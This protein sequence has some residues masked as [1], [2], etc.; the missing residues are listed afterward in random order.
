MIQAVRRPTLVIAGT[1]MAGGRLVEEILTN[2]PERF[3]IRMFGADPQTL[4]DRV[5]L[6]CML[7][8][9]ADAEQFQLRPMQWFE[10]RGVLVHAGV[11]AEQIDR[12]QRLVVGGGGK[13]VE[14]YDLLVLATGS[15]PLVPALPGADLQG[16]FVLR[17]LDDW[18]GVGA[19]AHECDR[20]VI[21][22]GG[23]LGLLAERSLSKLGLEV[24]IVEKVA[25]VH[26]EGFV[27]GVE[28]P[29]GT[30]LDADLLVL[31]GGDHPNVEP[32]RLAGL[33]IAH[34]V[35]VDDQMRTSDLDIYALG[36]CAQPRIGDAPPVI[37]QARLLAGLL[38]GTGP[39]LPPPPEESAKNKVETT[40]QDK[41]GLDCLPDILKLAPANNW[42]ELTEDD[43]HRAKW[44]GLFFRKQTPGHFMMR[45][46]A[47]AGQMTAQQFRVI[48]DIS[49]EFGKGFVDITTRQQIQLRWFALRDVEEIWR[50]LELVGIHSKQTG[51]DNV[52]GVCGCPV[53]GLTPSELFDAS[54]VV[55]ELSDLIVG[56]R[57][58]TNLPRKFNVTITACLENCCHTET[59][60]IALVPAYRELEDG[61]IDGFN[62]FVGG[63]QGSGGY[64]PATPLDVF[65][66]REE[67]AALSGEIIRVFRDH[68]SRATRNR[69]RLA[70]LIEDRGIA[71]LRAEVER[72]WGRALLKSGTDLRKP[73]H[74][75]HLGIHPQKHRASDG[76]PQLYYAG[77][78]VPVGR[79]TSAQ[80]RGVADLADRHGNGDIRIT[81]GQNIIIANIPEGHIGAL[82]DEPLL[83]ELEIDPSPVMRGLVACTGTDYCHLALIET[84]GWAVQVARELEKRTAGQKLKPLTIHW[85][86]CSAGCGLHQVSTIGLQGCRS[87]VNGQVLDAA[88]VCVNGKTGPEPVVATDLMYDVPCEQLADALEPLVRYLPR[89]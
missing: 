43:K 18:L 14:P 19:F 47:N 70:F 77:M 39:E 80:L 9:V 72:R 45:L 54:P 52:R 49:D 66:R 42:Q 87:R 26:G 69:A 6:S 56:N 74:V 59:Q 65:V 29:D 75:D 62:I 71:W 60:D 55:K 41:D 27:R 48:A 3:H 40:K 35:L 11:K 67:A 73:H 1:G 2:A 5:L 13:V 63:K 88:H 28:L 24:A 68:G 12:E 22:G 21:L 44:H 31:A 34:G 84:K 37:G 20:A 82:A 33:E 78:L 4:A 10:E 64:A 57:E 36:E 23:R 86:G 50:R 25:H 85:S 89:S 17:T 79:I 15:K 7:D 16:V 76:G 30:I 83:K 8:G 46:R 38:V 53:A 81:P 32:A 51:M 58:F 61:K